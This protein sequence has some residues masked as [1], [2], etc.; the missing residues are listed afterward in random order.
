MAAEQSFES[1]ISDTS[2][3]AKWPKPDVF[4]D[5]IDRHLANLKAMPAVDR[6]IFLMKEM[7]MYNVTEGGMTGMEHGTRISFPYA[8]PKGGQYRI[9]LQ[10]K[11]NEKV[12]TGA[13]DVKV[14]DPVTL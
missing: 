7:G 13:F 3:V 12:L 5:S 2:H 9:F 1:R 14:N 8:F 6:E 11:R 10:I 4:R